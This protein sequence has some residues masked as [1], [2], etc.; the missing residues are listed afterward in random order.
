MSDT[1]PRANP[2]L[3]SLALLIRGSRI[4][5]KYKAFVFKSLRFRAIN[6]YFNSFIYM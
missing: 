6:Y 3:D 1:I 2:I 4:R 5:A